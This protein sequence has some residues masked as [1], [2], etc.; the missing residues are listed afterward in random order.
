LIGKS[1][2]EEEESGSGEIARRTACLKVARGEQLQ[3]AG[4]SKDN[5]DFIQEL[6][7]SYAVPRYR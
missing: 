1:S 4:L 5:D 2:N 6:V 7:V 3:F